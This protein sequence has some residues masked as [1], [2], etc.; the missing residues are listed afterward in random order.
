MTGGVL[1]KGD[2]SFVGGNI[3]LWRIF[4]GDLAGVRSLALGVFGESKEGGTSL[5]GVLGTGA[6]ISLRYPG[7]R[8]SD[9]LLLAGRE[10]T[11]FWAVFDTVSTS[12]LDQPKQQDLASESGIFNYEWLSYFML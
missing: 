11:R 10:E 7:A 9:R 1:Q 2:D 3:V 4:C 8:E 5:L 12:A 6:R